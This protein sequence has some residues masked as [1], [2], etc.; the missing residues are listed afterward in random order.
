M[1]NAPEFTEAEIQAELDRMDAQQRAKKE[2]AYNKY[3]KPAQG[4]SLPAITQTQS[5]EAKA[6]IAQIKAYREEADMKL[7]ALPN[8]Q[9]PTI[10]P[11]EFSSVEEAQKKQDARRAELNKNLRPGSK[12]SEKATTTVG[13]PT[14]LAD[15]ENVTALNQAEIDGIRANLLAYKKSL[16]GIEQAYL[17]AGTTTKLPGIVPTFDEFQSLMTEQE[18]KNNLYGGNARGYRTSR[19]GYMTNTIIPDATITSKLPDIDIKPPKD[20]NFNLQRT[21]SLEYN[22][23]T[24][25]YSD[26]KQQKTSSGKAPLVRNL[27]VVNLS[28]QS[29]D[30]LEALTQVTRDAQDKLQPNQANYDLLKKSLEATTKA[31][32]MQGTTTDPQA[33]MQNWKN[34]RIALEKAGGNWSSVP[35]QYKVYGAKKLIGWDDKAR[36]AVF[37]AQ[38]KDFIINL[39]NNV[40]SQIENTPDNEVIGTMYLNTFQGTEGAG[41]NVLPNKEAANNAK[42]SFPAILTRTYGAGL[43]NS[44]MA[45]VARRMWQTNYKKAYK[46]EWGRKSK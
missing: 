4:S 45:E 35:D 36:K 38:T 6:K 19:G 27:G 40:G 44:D 33:F 16:D 20:L 34:A 46:P 9:Q 32:G 25:E 26:E 41:K 18:Q 13:M 2:A 39:E 24:G 29:P 11:G 8:L 15:I 7:S 21:P 1:I 30:T 31:W 14:N 37:G 43:W 23:Y 42:L 17:N 28:A 22:E 5:P 3:Y 12:V 10:V